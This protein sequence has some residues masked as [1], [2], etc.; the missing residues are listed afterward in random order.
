MFAKTGIALVLLVGIASSALAAPKTYST[1]PAHDVFDL[2]ALT[3]QGLFAEEYD[4]LLEAARYDQEL[5]K[6]II[7]HILGAPK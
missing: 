1:N 7:E 6:K 4:A 3:D 5:R 2:R